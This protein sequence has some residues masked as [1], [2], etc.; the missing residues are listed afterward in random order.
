MI[1]MKK[2][3]LL[4]GLFVCSILS[5][6]QLKQSLSFYA[7]KCKI[8]IGAAV[9][10]K[11]YDTAVYDKGVTYDTIVRNNFNILVAENEMKFDA[12][13]PQQYNFNFTKSDKLVAYAQKYGK[14]VRGHTLCWHSQL[15]SWITTGLTN[16]IANGTFNRESLMAILKYH[17]TAVVKHHKGKVQQ[18]D[19]VNEAFRD[20]TDSLR[21]S[22]WQQVIGN[23]YIDS[24]FVWAHRADPDAKLYLNDYNVEYT[25]T[26]KADALY[27]FAKSMKNRNIPITGVGLQ[28]HFTTNGID[29]AKLDQNIKRYAAAGLEAIITELDI[30]IKKTD[31][32]ANKTAWLTAQADNYRTMIRICLDNPNCKTFITWGFTDLYSW[33]PG[34]SS[35]LYDYALLF[36]NAYAPK[37]AYLSI[38]DKLATESQKV[39]I[40]ELQIDSDVQ[41]KVSDDK[42]YLSSFKN[43][44][45]C[46]LFDFQGRSLFLSH[47]K[48]SQIEIPVQNK[49][50]NF[51][52]LRIQVENG[53]IFSR[54]I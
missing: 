18:W 16:G 24:A 20:V 6:A 1:P 38:L 49:Q 13:E 30:R 15:P 8:N 32:A 37:P 34:S 46:Q 17:I 42:I 43:I 23:D 54:K 11:F 40:K 25:G 19:V 4:F 22:I 36:D 14:Q 53:K 7:E 26:T 9:G 12:M 51:Y 28:C 10:S 5:S 31:Y 45:Y 3:T 47:K 35:N 39:A 21:A 44:T 52:I 33:I 27:N 2:L 50:N 41:I 29:F 48:D